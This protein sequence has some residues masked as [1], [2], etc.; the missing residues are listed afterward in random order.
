VYLRGAGSHP[1]LAVLEQSDRSALAGIAFE[2]DAADDLQRAIDLHGATAVTALD[3]PGGGLAVSLRDPEG[4]A[5]HLVHG[6][7]PRAA[8]RLA[9]TLTLNQGYENKPRRGAF[10]AKAPL[11]PPPL[12]RLG[13]VGLFTGNLAASREWYA[14]VLGLLPS[15]LMYAGQP[16]NVVA[17][18]FRLNRGEEFVDHHTLALFG[19]GSRGVHH[20]S[21]EVEN[22]EVQFMT[23]RWLA[24][25]GYE[26]I[27]GVG[28]HPKGSHVFDVWRD[29]SGFRFE[30]F[31]DTDLLDASQAAEP[32]P[33]QAAQMDLWSDRS[34]E[35]YFA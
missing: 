13:H 34:F 2:V 11:G 19:M 15:D 18:F 27:W 26:S 21:F 16:D 25:K 17:G 33:I 8:D 22:S 5:I 23:H 4:I 20:L 35:P 3:A 1:Y 28:R 10:Q 7:E 29:P 14:R 9:N 6:I 24:S 30:T 32:I 12:L 31:S